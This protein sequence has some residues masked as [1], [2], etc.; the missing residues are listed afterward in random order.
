MQI[1][2]EYNENYFNDRENVP[3]TIYA[4]VCKN[5]DKIYVGLTKYRPELRWAEHIRAAKRNK[6]NN[7]MHYAMRKYGTDSFTQIIL[8]NCVGLKNAHDIEAYWINKLDTYKNGYN[9]TPGGLGV[10]TGYHITDDEI[11]NHAIDF[12]L[13]NN[14]KFD[15]SKWNAYCKKIHIPYW[16][17]GR[18]NP[19]VADG[20]I[21]ATDS[22]KNFL[23]SVNQRLVS[24]GHV[25]GWV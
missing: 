13:S 1:G 11:I 3:Y 14:K 9:S 22:L 4:H 15:R 5:T 23:L 16:V 17:Y 7:K 20:V 6:T 25:P 12:F 2:Y 19:G 24:L 10:N 21:N 8:C 18:F